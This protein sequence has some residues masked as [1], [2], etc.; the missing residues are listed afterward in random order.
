MPYCADGCYFDI[1]AQGRL[2]IGPTCNVECLMGCIEIVDVA[3]MPG[4]FVRD[5]SGSAET[6]CGDE[7]LGDHFGSSQQWP[8]RFDSHSIFDNGNRGYHTGGDPLSD[9]PTFLGSSQGRQ[10][11]PESHET[12]IIA[13]PSA[14]HQDDASIE[15]YASVS[16]QFLNDYSC[17]VLVMVEAS[18]WY[19]DLANLPLSSSGG[20]RW[21]GEARVRYRDAIA[22][23]WIDMEWQRAFE[24]LVIRRPNP[25]W[26]DD[27]MNIRGHMTGPASLGEAMEAMFNSVKYAMGVT[28]LELSKQFGTYEVV[29]DVPGQPGTE[30]SAPVSASGY[31]FPLQRSA[32]ALQSAC[33]NNGLPGG[34]DYNAYRSTY[35]DSR[36]GGRRHKGQDIMGATGATV[37]AVI[38]GSIGQAG[39]LSS[40]CGISILLNGSDGG[41]YRY[42]HLDSVSVS[43]GAEVTAGQVIGANGYS[44]NAWSSCPH[45]H[46][47]IA[48]GNVDP[49]PWLT[50]VWNASADTPGGTTTTDPVSGGQVTEIVQ[51]TE[52]K[53]RAAASVA[54]IDAINPAI[55]QTELAQVAHRIVFNDY[56]EEDNSSFADRLVKTGGSWQMPVVLRPGQGIM[57]QTRS[58]FGRWSYVPMV[59]ANGFFFNKAGGSCR[60]GKITMT[61]Y[62]IFGSSRCDDERLADGPWWGSMGIAGS[63]AFGTEGN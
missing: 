24:T 29:H 17:P 38:G 60:A 39:Y 23:P 12:P 40:T 46:F 45:I 50:D 59:P 11:V 57:A 32:L 31:A 61:V 34:A 35:G 10:W 15:T 33:N 54:C 36:S 19:H 13:G 44:G 56:Q 63:V 8:K 27:I 26:N 21:M 48:S 2:R 51:N 4:H 5:P 37:H 14:L 16:L 25:E 18:N 53:E 47:E 42:C 9:D 3:S 58:R 1:D 7:C 52:V 62:P 55:I 6:T 28:A 30:V 49:H 41:R 43:A 22:D 20:A